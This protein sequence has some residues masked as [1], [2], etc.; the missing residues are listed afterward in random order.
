MQAAHRGHQ[1]CCQLL[2]NSG[3]NVDEQNEKLKT[4]LMLAVLGGHVSIVKVLLEHGHANT[5]I[6]RHRGELLFTSLLV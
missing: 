6:K 3:A 2:L 4:S 1:D 5:E